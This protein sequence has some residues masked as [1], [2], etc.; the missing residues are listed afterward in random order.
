[1]KW[2]LG[3]STVQVPYSPVLHAEY[4]GI[5]TGTATN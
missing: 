1:M 4:Y 2:L 5:I 3:I